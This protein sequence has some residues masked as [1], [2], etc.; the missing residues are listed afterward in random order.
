MGIL[1][2]NAV[3]HI[4]D[5][6][7][8]M[9][10]LSRRELELT[11]AVYLFLEKTIVKLFEDDNARAAECG[12]VSAR[13]PEIC[14]EFTRGLDLIT[15][16]SEIANLLFAIMQSQPE[17]PPADLVCTLFNRDDTPYFG[18][19]KLNYRTGFIHMVAGDADTCVNSLI[20]QKT[21]LP[22]ET[23]KLEEAVAVNLIDLT[24]TLIEKEYRIDGSRDY[25]LSKTLFECSGRLSNNQKAKV[26]AKVTQKVSQKYYDDP[27]EPMARMRKAV[28]ESC[29]A[30]E[31]IDMDRVVRE[32]FRDDPLAGRE[33]LEEIRRAGIE[34]QAVHL[35]EKVVAR[36]FGSQKIRTDTGVEINFPSDYFNDR[37]KVEFINNQDGTISI[38][39]KNVNK[40]ISN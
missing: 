38:I 10:V 25:Y 5:A 39:I 15:G 6:N 9:P 40:I 12:N 37:E 14:R 19:F 31:G 20:Q 23:Q 32:A 28:V 26:I 33:Y 3:L 7:L 18:M 1:I 11:E 29:D 24:L 2:K 17:I 22:S 8:G 21:V 16:S 36:K 30:P 35:P 4:L 34:E 27:F 13:I